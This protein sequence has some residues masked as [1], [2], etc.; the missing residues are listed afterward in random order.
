MTYQRSPLKHDTRA[1]ARWRGS[2]LAALAA[3]LL[4]AGSAAAQAPDMDPDAA[5]PVM[6]SLRAIRA[7]DSQTAER[8]Y[9]VRVRATV[10]HYDGRPGLHGRMFIH[11]GQVGL[12]V[13]DKRGVFQGVLLEIGDL[14]EVEGY[15]WSGGFAPTIRAIRI[16]KVGKGVLPAPKRLSYEEMATGRNDCEWVEVTGIPRATRDDVQGLEGLLRVQ[17]ALPGGR[18][19]AYFWDH[20][21]GDKTRLVDAEVRIRG[22]LGAQFNNRKQLMGLNL[23]CG[24]AREIEVLRTAVANPFAL[25]RTAVAQVL[26]FGTL[27]T[28]H[29]IRV[30]GVVTLARPGDFLYVQDDTSGIHVEVETADLPQIGDTVDAVGF[31]VIVADTKPMLGNA[32]I[33]KTGTGTL[34]E[35][36]ALAPGQEVD[37]NDDADVVQLDATLLGR[38]G[39]PTEQVLV[40]KAGDLVFDTQLVG[41]EAVGLQVPREGSSVRLAGIYVY[42]PARTGQAATFRLLLRSA[43]D[44]T[45]LRE[46]AWWT[47]RHSLIMLTIVGLVMAVAAAWVR[48]AARK[49]AALARAND[50]LAATHGEL[51]GTHEQLRRAHDELESILAEAKDAA[52]AVSSASSQILA[53]STEIA[54]GAQYGSDQVHSTSAA[55]EELA[56]S[57][58]QVTKDA[59][60]SSDSASKVIDHLRESDA[61]VNA[62]LDGMTRIDAAVS[63]TAAKMRL[64]GQRSQEIF[65]IIDLIE[66]IAS[67]SELLSL[68]AA[69]EAA[70]AGEAGHG[71]AVVAAEIRHLAERST[72][73][74]KNVTSLVRA[75]NSETQAALSA[76][77]H[78]MREVK[79]GVGLSGQ[80]RERLGDITTLVEHAARLASQILGAAREQTEVTQRVSQSMQ[81]IAGV[82]QESAAAA[83]ETTKAVSDLVAMAEQLSRSIARFKSTRPGA[84]SA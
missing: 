31:P 1:W 15:T 58:S 25:P 42:R 33:R 41:K 34:P 75:I 83:T 27:Q 68:N 20:A 22:V 82:T 5:L 71:F 76:M 36:R 28:G 56:A 69:I 70:H 62:T 77:E 73:A 2:V 24:H 60:A 38:V 52:L 51:G 50:Q 67:R 55:V 40:L 46:A 72:E 57:M 26:Q 66:E 12:N 78:G 47:W 14:A 74:T 45:V 10:T 29:R 32:V 59:G 6:T 21:P 53:A 9:P 3:P 4:C 49:N 30:S 48:M 37:S 16:T 7:M 65:E 19:M 81:T 43:K 44:L 63:E 64:L 23:I 54:K 8:R 79:Q 84:A 80:A 35:A 13:D 39:T 17:V 18:I 11:D 61:A